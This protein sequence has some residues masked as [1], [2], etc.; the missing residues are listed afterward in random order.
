MS[1]NPIRAPFAAVIALLVVAPSADRYRRS[2]WQMQR[3]ESGLR[4]NRVHRSSVD[5]SAGRHT[6]H[7]TAT[8]SHLRLPE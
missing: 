3:S 2:R 6:Q 1:I 4:R 5:V 8:L 7:D